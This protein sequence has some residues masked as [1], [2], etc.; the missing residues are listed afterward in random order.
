MAEQPPI[1]LT[2][3]EGEVLA[4]LF[5]TIRATLLAMGGGHAE[6]GVARSAHGG[7]ISSGQPTGNGGEGEP[8]SGPSVSLTYTGPSIPI[9]I[10]GTG[11]GGNPPPGSEHH[12]TVKLTT[13]L[14]YLPPS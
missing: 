7:G 1:H 11:S 9:I 10:P 12:G 14:E 13:R 2:E 4:A 8:S 3:S 6:A 5:D